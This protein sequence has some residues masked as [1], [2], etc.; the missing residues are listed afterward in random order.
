MQQLQAAKAAAPAGAAS[1][2]TN[3]ANNAIGGLGKIAG[4]AAGKLGVGPEIVRAVTALLDTPAIKIVIG[5][6]LEKLS[7]C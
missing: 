3:A 4:D 5:S 2:V 1:T 7:G 6:T